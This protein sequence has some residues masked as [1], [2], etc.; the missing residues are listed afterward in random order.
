MLVDVSAN[1]DELMLMVGVV[2]VFGIVDV[3][4]V[5]SIV[6]VVSVVSL[7][8]QPWRYVVILFYFGCL[9]TFTK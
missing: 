8:I 5:V 7:V 9:C 2:G 3:V 4:S 1:G 6:C